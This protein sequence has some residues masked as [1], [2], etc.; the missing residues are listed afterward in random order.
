MA[1]ITTI[2]TTIATAGFYTSMVAASALTAV[3]FGGIA[4]GVGAL[5]GY[6]VI[7]GIVY[8]GIALSKA[9]TGGKRATSQGVANSPTLSGNVLQTQTNNQLPIPL[10]YGE[11]K[12]AG[13]RI[14]QSDTPDPIKRIVAFADGGDYGIEGFSEIKLNDIPISEI[15]GASYNPY[16]GASTQLIDSIVPG[17]TNTERAQKVG[18]LK[19]LAYLAIQCGRTDKINANYNLTTFVKGRKV[20]IYSSESSYTVSY[21]NNPAWCLLDF[22]TAYNGA[23]IGVKNDG[24]R[25][26]V[27]ISKYIDIN[28]F[29]EAATYCDELIT[30]YQLNTS[31]AGDKNDLLFKARKAG[32]QG[33]SLEYLNPSLPDQTASISIDLSNKI[34]VNLATNS[35]SQVVTTANDIISLV[36]N[37]PEIL[38]HIRVYK[39]D[40]NDGTGIVTELSEASFSA[41]AGSKRFTFNMIFDS[42]FSVRDVIEEFKKNCRGSL[43][44]K[45][46]KLQ[47][48]IDKPDSVRKVFTLED[49]KGA[50]N[51]YTVPKEEH[52]DILKLEYVSPLHQW[53]KVQAQAELSE[54]KNEP[55]IS[56]DVDIYS[57]TSFEQAARLAWYYINSKRLCP[58]FGDF[59]ADYKAF[60]LEIGD[61]IQIDIELLALTD[62]KVKV[63]KVIDD[64]SGVFKVHWRNYSEELYTDE[65]GSAEPTLLVT[66]ISSPYAYPNDVSNF[67]VVQNLRLLEFAWTKIN[68]IDTYEIRQGD[69][70]D[71]STLIATGIKG[72][73]YTANLSKKGTLKFWIK[74]YTGIQYSQNPALDVIQVSIIPDLNI[75]VEQKIFENL[76]GIFDKTYISAGGL[77]LNALSD[78][79]WTDMAPDIWQSSGS[80]IYADINNRWTPQKVESLGSYISQVYDLGANLSSIISY[81][82]DIYLIDSSSSIAVEFRCSEDNTTWSDWQLLNTGTYQFRYYQIRITLNSPNNNPVIISDLILTIDVP[83]RVEDYINRQITSADDGITIDFATDVES[84]IKSAFIIAEPQILPASKSISSYPV[85]ISSAPGSC[86]VKLYDNSGALV[87]GFVNIQVRGY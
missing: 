27:V 21:S 7:G 57:I 13:N 65:L 85:V 30:Y 42:Q 23:A 68:D 28:S 29:I 53:S 54:Y 37:N 36:N 46:Q 79:I 19:Y 12:L 64:G 48:K 66:N 2:L 39:A 61:V 56:H 60:D 14:W 8:G 26:D 86:T 58:L 10:L 43:V 34:T 81:N 70:W 33:I 5:A 72:G 22:L 47:F 41:G 35:S 17:N 16:L 45:G 75:V 32:N 78:F 49:I 63:T 25:D 31:L 83:D 38:N 20:R 62:Y 55:A 76:A 87:T 11:F 69:S 52:Y 59:E 15:S 73:S 50:E 3:G 84:K 67:N 24:S 1:V 71:N 40:D 4:A 82:Y 80:R 18:S 9:L 74:A 77:K 44:T 51:I 6:S